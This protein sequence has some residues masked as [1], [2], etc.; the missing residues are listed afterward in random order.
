MYLDFVVLEI[1]RDWLREPGW[2]ATLDRET[3]RALLVHWRRRR[4]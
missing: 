4:K 1:E 3:Q 2:F